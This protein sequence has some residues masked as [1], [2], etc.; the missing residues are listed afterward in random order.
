V[1]GSLGFIPGS[2]SGTTQTGGDRSID[3]KVVIFGGSLL[4]TLPSE[5]QLMEFFLAG[6]AGGK[7]HSPEIGDSQTNPYGSVGAGL[8]IFVTPTTALRFDVRD[9]I[10]PYTDGNLQNDVLLTAGLS[11]S[12]SGS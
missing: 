6:G 3:T 2:Y 8:R 4:Y 9:Y 1:E 11:F 7:M 12:P 10:S 5:N